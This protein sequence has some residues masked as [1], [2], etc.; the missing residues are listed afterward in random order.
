MVVVQQSVPLVLAGL[1]A[2]QA[3]TR[4]SLGLAAF[5]L[6]LSIPV[7]EAFVRKEV[8]FSWIF[9][10]TIKPPWTYVIAA[11]FL[12][13]IIPT[14]LLTLIGI[15]LVVYTCRYSVMCIGQAYLLGIFQLPV[16]LWCVM[17][18]SYFLLWKA[19]KFTP[20]ARQTRNT[21]MYV[22]RQNHRQPSHHQRR[23]IT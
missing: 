17:M 11:C 12:V 3:G 5:L 14:I 9:A 19:N 4:I 10:A 15:L 21:A 23:H 18:V 2:L 1:T 6:V 22:S 16:L 8:H 20:S 7:W 13:I